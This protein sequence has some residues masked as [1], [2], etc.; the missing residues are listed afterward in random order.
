MTLDRSGAEVQAGTRRY[1]SLA[2]AG[3]PLL[4]SLIWEQ[5][6]VPSPLPV[7]VQLRSSVSSEASTR[8]GGGGR[9]RIR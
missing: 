3:P 5:P 9:P 2:A 1:V 7:F 6:A 8:L 4:L